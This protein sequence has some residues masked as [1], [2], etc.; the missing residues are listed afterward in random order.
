VGSSVTTCG[1][2]SS[3]WPLEGREQE[4]EALRLAAQQPDVAGITYLGKSG[5][6]KTRLLQ[7]LLAWASSAGFP[8]AWVA[9]TKAAGSI[10]LGAFAHLLHEA[11]VGD[12]ASLG[13]FP[14]AVAALARP[15][16]GQRLI[17]AIDDAHLLDHTSAALVHE[18]VRTGTAFVVAT[19]ASD[20]PVP[21]PIVALWRQG[22]LDRLVLPPLQPDTVKRLLAHVLGGDVTR[23]TLHQFETISQGDLTLLEALVTGGLE[24]GAFVESGGVWRWTGQCAVPRLVEI[25][26]SRLE[27]LEPDERLLLEILAM[28]KKLAPAVLE[29]LVSPAAIVSVE[30]KGVITVDHDGRRIGVRITH[31]LC[32]EALRAS[33]PPLRARALRCQLVDATQ[34]VGGRRSD[35]LL[36]V[37]TWRLEAGGANDAEALMSA[38][39]QAQSGFDHAL[40]ERLARA[41]LEEGGG[42]EA[43]QLLSRAAIGQG[44]LEEAEHILLTAGAETLA[45]M[46]Q[47]DLLA[48]RSTNLFWALD[49]ASSAAEALARAEELLAGDGSCSRVEALRAKVSLLSGR[50]LEALEWARASLEFSPADEEIRLSALLV[51]ADAWTAHGRTKEALEAAHAGI[52]LTAG[53]AQKLP[54]ARQSLI[55]ASAVAYRLAGELASAEA[56]TDSGYQESLEQRNAEAHPMWA[57][58]L[59]QTALAQGKV[60]TAADWFQEGATLSRDLGPLGQLPRCLANLAHALALTGDHVG[61]QTALAE[62]D[63]LPGGLPSLF[64]VDVA[65]ARAWTT[66]ARGALSEASSIALDAAQTAH[67][68]GHLSLAAIAFH[69]V[70]RLG[71][72]RPARGPLATLASAVDSPLMQTFVDHAAALTAGDGHALDKVAGAFEAMGASLLAA[73]AVSEAAAAHRRTGRTTQGVASSVKA[74]SLADQCEGARTPALAFSGSDPLTRREREIVTLAAQ[75]LSNRAIA[76]RLVVSTRTV[77]NHIHRAYIKLGVSR[78]QHL[79]ETIG[80]SGAQCLPVTARAAE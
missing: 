23:A 36:S 51:A 17:L 49:R 63:S 29:A 48:T 6:G 22:L 20:R 40:A 46:E 50:P 67:A 60:R 59:G 27:S 47:A 76:L 66:A 14:T 21:E 18:V 5:A 35:D 9:A 58:L 44:R 12:D 39:R 65:L 79:T 8:T 45:G 34:A 28:S 71:A 19:M 74:K 41:A 10:P 25:V 61:A 42:L 43:R 77:E 55:A 69:E 70:V 15:T 26:E 80:P 31:P 72:A 57:L 78:R 52:G 68:S 3:V 73:E 56:V 30:R 7:E 53:C 62:L 64:E 75:G 33:I 2:S 32:A 1:R 16:E 4:L 38:A 11:A 37:V 24:V 13:F 54:N